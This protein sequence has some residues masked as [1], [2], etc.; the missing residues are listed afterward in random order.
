MCE[1]LLASVRSFFFLQNFILFFVLFFLTLVEVKIIIFYL[2]EFSAEKTLY[3]QQQQQRKNFVCVSLTIH[4]FVVVLH[5]VA[6]FIR[7]FHLNNEH[8]ATSFF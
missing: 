7:F 3:I 4:L 8:Q 6:S 2:D 5:D 1:C